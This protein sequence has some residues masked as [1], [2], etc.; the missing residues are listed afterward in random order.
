M[1]QAIRSRNLRKSGFPIINGVWSKNGAIEGEAILGETQE[2]HEP[3]LEAA[4]VAESAA[5]EAAV[6]D[7]SSRRIEDIPPEDIEPIGQ[8]SEVPLPSSQVGSLIR[9]ALDYISQGEP[10]VHEP[11]IE[12][13][14]AE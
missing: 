13:S 14:V 11:S 1:G 9:D 4:A 3:I 5:A 6:V 8:F 12:K 2:D 10:V 7:E